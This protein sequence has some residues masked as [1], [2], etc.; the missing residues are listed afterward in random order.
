MSDKFINI[1]LD[2]D[3][4]DI[5][6]V[7]SSIYNALKS[8]SHGFSGKLLDAGCGKMPY[9]EYILSNTTVKQYVGLDIENALSYDAVIKPDVLWDGRKMPFADNNF[10]T[11]ISTEV[12]EHCKTPEIYLSEVNRVLK[13]EGVFFFTVPFLWPL[14]ET[15]NDYYRYTPFSL[16]ELLVNAGFKNIELKA[17]G[18]YDASLSVMLGLWLKRHLRSKA[19]KIKLLK[20]MLLPVIKWLIKR[21]QCPQSFNEGQMITGIYGLARK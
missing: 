16:K 20:H 4:I 1:R 5:Y 13:K 15:P 19:F 7:R 2:V 10:E 3:T 6:Y 12:L 8:F 17:L 21:D 11:V 14:H 18:G 9:K